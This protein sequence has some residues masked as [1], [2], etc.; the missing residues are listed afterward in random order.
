MIRT[1]I[2]TSTLACLFALASGHAFCDM[3]NITDSLGRHVTIETPV[4][5]IIALGN[6]RLEAITVLSSADRVVGMDSDSRESSIF[7][8]PSLAALPDVGTWK[9]PNHEVIAELQPDL[10]ITSANSERLS[11][12][13]DKLR[14]FGVVLVGLDF[15]RD[16]TLKQEIQTLGRILGK[17]SQARRYLDWRHKYEKRIADHVATLS[18][19][20][21]PRVYLE[22]GDEAGRSW[23]KGDSGDVMC[24]NTGGMNLVSETKGAMRVSMEWLSEQNPD[25][26]VKCIKLTGNRWGWPDNREPGVLLQSVSRRSGPDLTRAVRNNRVYVY[27]SEIAWGLDSIVASAYFLRW[28]HPKAAIDPEAIYR[29]Y[30]ATFLKIDFPEGRV[31]AYPEKEINNR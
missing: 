19:A 20:Q 22:W 14:P 29:E 2:F 16:D 10:V 23:G 4:K 27:C 24:A 25:V 1:L 28:F 3:V 13:E 7:Y 9:A 15:F 26:I 21:R 8:F 31:F 18:D 11:P 30:V 12:L 6:Y 17:E 5:R